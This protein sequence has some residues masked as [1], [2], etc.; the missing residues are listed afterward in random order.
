MVT[1]CVSGASIF[2]E[3]DRK[4]REETREMTVSQIQDIGEVTYMGSAIM[5]VIYLSSSR[6]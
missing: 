2:G 5:F 4:L 3:S 1:C 6:S